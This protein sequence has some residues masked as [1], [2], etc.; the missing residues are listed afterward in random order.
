MLPGPTF[1]PD[2]GS[3]RGLQQLEL[4]RLLLVWLSIYIYSLHLEEVRSLAPPK[5]TEVV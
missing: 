3:S 1:A 5:R 2:G 4:R